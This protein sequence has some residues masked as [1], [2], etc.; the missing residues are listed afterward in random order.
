MYRQSQY[1]RVRQRAHCIVLSYQ[2][3]PAKELQNIF[4]V[5]LLTIS[6]WFDAWELRRFGGLY[7]K[8][9]GGSRAKLHHEQR[10]KIRQWAKEFPK[11]LRKIGAFIHEEFGI[12][13]SKDTLKR[14]LK[15]LRVSWHR[16]RRKVKGHPDPQ[17]YQQKKEELEE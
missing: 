16:V 7:D 11:N 15:M 8:K 4:Q 2:G 5:N 9:G 10:E 14:L 13:V 6:Q 1:Y 17:A 3:Y 12:T